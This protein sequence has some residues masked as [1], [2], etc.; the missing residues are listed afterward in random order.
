MTCKK[1]LTCFLKTA[2]LPVGTTM[3]VYGG[4]W[5]EADTG[6]GVE[7]VTLGLSEEWAKFAAMQDAAYDHT[8]YR[9]QIHKG[10]DCSGYVGWVL[11]NTWEEQSGC[12]GYVMP[13]AKM[14][15]TFASWGWGK[16]ISKDK[17]REFLPGDIVSMKDH[18][19]I[20]LGTCFDGSVLLIHAS[21]PGISLCGTM[22]PVVE[23]EKEKKSQAVCLAEHYMKTYF[24]NWYRRYPNCSRGEFYKTESSVMRWGSKVLADPDGVQCMSPQTLLELLL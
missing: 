21:P 10:L 22:L 6:A 3:Y 7:A 15:E 13:A 11:Y 20:S 2:L 23:G 8:K 17:K 5:N 1:T 18:V 19:W 16:L 9:Y 4:G 24:P 14:A 12:V